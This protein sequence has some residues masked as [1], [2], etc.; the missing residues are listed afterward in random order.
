MYLTVSLILTELFLHLCHLISSDASV[1]P[2]K[3]PPS[4]WSKAMSTKKNEKRK[5]K[6]RNNLDC[7]I[8][9]NLFMI[10]KSQGMMF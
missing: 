5:E 10:T 8:I 3:F 6:K 1:F 7:N 4:Q 2:E 9:P